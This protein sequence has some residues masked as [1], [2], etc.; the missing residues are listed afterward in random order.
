MSSG[1]REAEPKTSQGPDIPDRPARILIVDDERH[2]RQ[3]LEVMLASEGFVLSTA[4][5]GEEALAMVAQQPFDLILLDLRMTGLDGSQVTARI[6]DNPAT[7]HIPVIMVTAVDDREARMLGLGA[8]AEDFLSKPV[9]RAELRV[10]VRNLLRLKAYGEAYDKYSQIL[11]GEV[12]SRTADLVERTTTL[13]ALRR[14]YELVLDSI[15]DGVHGID[16]RDRITIANQVATQMFGWDERELVGRLAHQT[17]HHTRAD[18]TPHPQEECPIHRTLRDGESRRVTDEVFWRKDGGSFPVEYL[19]APMRDADGGI[20]G[21]VVTFRD[22]TARRDAERQQRESEEQYRVLFEGNPQPMYV[23]D[24]QTLAFLAVNDAA[25]QHYGHSREE[26]LSM[27]MRDISRAEEIPALIDSIRQVP[28]DTASSKSFGVCAHRRK[29]GLVM[30][31]DIACSR[32]HFQGHD[33]FL[34]LAMDVTEKQSLEAQLLQS[35]KM[36][37]VGRLAGGIAHDFNNLLGVILGYGGLLLGKIESGPDRTK[38]EQIV[39]AGERAAGLTRQLLAFSRKQVLQPRVLDLNDLVADME[40][41]LRRLI[42]E[43]IQLTTLLGGRGNVK[44]DPGQ[45][46]QVLMNLVINARDAMPRGGQLTIQTSNIVLDESYAAERPDVRPGACV[47]LAVIDTGVGMTPETQRKIFEPFFTTKGLSEG[48]GLGLATSDGII[49]QSGGHIA[50]TSEPGHGSTFRVYLPRVDEEVPATVASPTLRRVGT[51]TILLAEDEPA[52]R[53]ITRDILEE[54]GY[55]VIEAGSGD[56]ALKLAREHPGDIGL[57]L[58]DVVMPR[59]GGRELAERLVRQRPRLQVM[60]MSG[61]TD[62]AVVR[63]GVLATSAAFIQKPFG[64]ESLL[65]KIREV[66]EQ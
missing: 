14:Q 3:L 13:E 64:S 6:K 61:Y 43:E 53:E 66:L 40:K 33:A 54:H 15:A 58:T 19:A 47:T 48:T 30:Q 56:G 52:L 1:V 35:Q 9:D 4:A 32:L 18:G 36:E 63:H 2:H 25:L 51:E 29:D 60:F 28:I 55:T 62:D 31:M 16:L 42:G 50:V 23:F 27:S 46:E 38:L 34:C 8:G 17:I 11:E 45:I 5:S 41:M 26:L 21:V 24:A 7:R 59:M 57:L 12:V 22:I 65:A 49:R 37:S 39:K 44:A 20:A 10:R